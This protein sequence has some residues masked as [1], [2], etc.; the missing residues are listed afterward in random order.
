[1]VNQ[2]IFL[3]QMDL[4]IAWKGNSLPINIKVVGHR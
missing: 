4:I 3:E 2:F 1:M